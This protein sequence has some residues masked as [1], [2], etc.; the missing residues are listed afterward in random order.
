MR[1]SGLV[2]AF[3]AL[4]LAQSFAGEARQPV[5]E[6]IMQPRIRGTFPAQGTLFADL[7]EPFASDEQPVNATIAVDS[8][9]RFQEI[10][11]FGYTLT[12]GSALV[13]SLMDAAPRRALLEEL[14]A[15]PPVGIGVSYLRVSIGSSDLDPETFSYSMPP[16]GETD[17]DLELFTLDHDREYL[18]PMLREIL[19]IRP[20]LLIMASPWSAPTWMKSNFRTVGG[21]L[22]SEYQGVYAQYFVRYVQEMASEGIRIDAVTVQNEPLHGGNNPSMTMLDFQQ[23]EFVRDHLGPAFADAGIGTRIIIYDHNADR[24]DYPL[25]V[26][27]DPDAAAYVDG[28]A[29]HLYGGEISALSEVHEAYPDKRIYFTEQWVGAPGDMIRDLLWHTENLIVGATRN[30]SRIVLQ[31]NLAADPSQ[32]PHTPGGCDRC[33]GALTID[34]NDV[35]R[36]P[37]FYIIAQASAFVPRG[38]IRVGSNE[39]DGLPNVAFL[40]PDDRIVLIVANTGRRE[41][42]VRIE[43]GR[44]ATTAR[45][46]ARGVVSYSWEIAR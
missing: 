32:D 16:S 7:D 37:A 14:F 41:R 2:V 12:G 24:L 36:N 22:K 17:P 34:G 43:L 28:T 35:V 31:W 6:D 27:S 45:L 42:N 33:L 4:A 23:A 21:T 13:L 8:R 10:D 3:F 38:S 5:P 15:D 19:Q 18:I 46:P 9:E 26:L 25:R 30:W 29:F 1:T 20:D 39:V 44:K 11:G 40:T